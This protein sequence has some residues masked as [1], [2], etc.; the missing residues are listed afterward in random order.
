MN[1]VSFRARQRA[2]E[3]RRRA[4]EAGARAAEL[5]G[6]RTARSAVNPED[7]TRALERAREL[8]KEGYRHAAAAERAAGRAHQSAATSCDLRAETRPDDDA[9]TLR[10][11]AS[12]HREHAE[13]HFRRA[14]ID[15]AGLAALED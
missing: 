9:A 5:A 12:E 13:E 10:A 3:A 6:D 2:E 7:S 11:A 14:L 8:A 1:D 15:D 4:A